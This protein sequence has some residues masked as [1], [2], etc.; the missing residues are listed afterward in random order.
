[1][2][3]VMRFASFACAKMT[4]SLIAFSIA[5]QR[6]LRAHFDVHEPCVEC[7]E[8]HEILEGILAGVNPN[9]QAFLAVFVCGAFGARGVLFDFAVVD[10]IEG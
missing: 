3:A 7:V 2:L 5:K 6:S 4:A 10:F 9:W 1:M 8:V